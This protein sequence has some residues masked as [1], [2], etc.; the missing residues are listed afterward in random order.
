MKKVS[1]IV[2]VGLAILMVVFA[3][4]V[5]EEVGQPIEQ[6]KDG[7]EGITQEEDQFEI[8]ESSESVRDAFERLY[9]IQIGLVFA[10]TMRGIQE[11][12]V[13]VSAIP[14][15]EEDN[16]LIWMVEV[17]GLLMDM[18]SAEPEIQQAA[19]EKGLI[20]FI[21]TN[22]RKVKPEQKDCTTILKF[23]TTEVK[24]AQCKPSLR[25][26]DEGPTLFDGLEE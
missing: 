14:T 25:S 24:A 10:D 13:I 5:T 15:A 21:P 26:D 1:V 11:V 16:P 4:C 2:L 17:N 9:G 23:P 18:R 20:P 19:F 6:H 3:S 7:D 8:E 22:A 12:C